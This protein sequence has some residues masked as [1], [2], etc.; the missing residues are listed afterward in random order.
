MG[1]DEQSNE[2]LETPKTA[3]NDEID[4]KRSHA[5]TEDEDDEEKKIELGP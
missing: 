3:A 4:D 1:L 2:V 5:L